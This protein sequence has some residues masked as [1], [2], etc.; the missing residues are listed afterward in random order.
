MEY[1]SKQIVK[2]PTPTGVSFADFKNWRKS[3]AK[4]FAV[5]IG[6]GVG[7]HP[8]QWAKANP[9]GQ[10]LA[11]ERTT[12]KFDK[13]KRRLSNHEHLRPQIFAAHSDARWLL[14]H[15][16]DLASVDKYYWLYPN[17]EPKRRNQRIAFS[18]LT[19]YVV[20]TLKPGG[21]LKIA[22]NIASYAD[23]VKQWLPRRF[24][25]NLEL[26]E[27]RSSKQESRSH[28]EKKYVARGDICF[29]IQF[30]KY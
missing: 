30:L 4:T 28:F 29:D 3:D 25:L 17:P 27:H 13:F 21:Q 7:L 15:F 1:D 19:D 6:C 20:A 12:N 18:T 24:P 22:T 2:T 23:E 10:I 5:E 11:I 14:P 9:K 16:L 26:S 8:I